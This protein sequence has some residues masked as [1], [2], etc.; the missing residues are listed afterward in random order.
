MNK[1]LRFVVRIMEDGSEIK[2]QRIRYDMVPCDPKWFGSND[3]L[4]GDDHMVRMGMQLCP[5][6][7]VMKDVLKV[8]NL[9]MNNRNRK[10]FALSAELC[11]GDLKDCYDEEKTSKMLKQVFFELHIYEERVVF[12]DNKYIGKR[13][14]TAVESFHS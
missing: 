12:G 9:F 3:T 7:D 6:M 8:E 14:I 10:Y 2:N 13:P 4:I 11:S 1:Y 5:D